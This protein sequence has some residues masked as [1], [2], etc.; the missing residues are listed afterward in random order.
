MVLEGITYDKEVK[1]E[2]AHDN[3]F[4]G[5]RP[6]VYRHRKFNN[7]MVVT[8]TIAGYNYTYL[9]DF[10][11]VPFLEGWWGQYSC[12][13]YRNVV[14][15]VATTEAAFVAT[16]SIGLLGVDLDDI[17]VS[18]I[19]G[20]KYRSDDAADIYGNLF[21]ESTAVSGRWYSQVDD[22]YGTSKTIDPDKPDDYITFYLTRLTI[23]APFLWIDN[24]KIQF[25]DEFKAG[26]EVSL[27]DIQSSRSHKAKLYKFDGVLR[28]YNRAFH[29]AIR[30]TIYEYEGVV[31]EEYQQY[32]K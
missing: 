14:S 4:L 19:K 12:P 27:D 23:S 31:P 18:P 11:P 29:C 10:G 5:F 26:G 22:F 17:V 3:L 6:Y 1:W 24:Q 8:D 2:E 32:I 15:Y 30:D 9:A 16:S 20:K 21:D 28:I 7:G 13:L 25:D